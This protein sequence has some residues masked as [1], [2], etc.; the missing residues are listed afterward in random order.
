M[1]AQ[2]TNMKFIS[3]II[4]VAPFASANCR[5]CVLKGET[6]D[7]LDCQKVCA[8]FNEC[9]CWVWQKST[10]VCTMKTMG[11]NIQPDNDSDFMS[12]CGDMAPKD[13]IN[14]I[15]NDITYEC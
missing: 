7:A 6:Y 11:S 10:S 5:V 12:G 14:I 3:L 9:G 13:N 8:G 4:L 2:N 1:G 15:G